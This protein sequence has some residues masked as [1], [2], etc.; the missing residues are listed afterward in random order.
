MIDQKE[1]KKL[2]THSKKHKGGMNSTHIK[3]MKKIMNINNTPF[4]VAHKKAVQLDNKNKKSKSKK[5][6]SN[7]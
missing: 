2:K 7:Y 6:K 4:I 5:P 1:M 3:N